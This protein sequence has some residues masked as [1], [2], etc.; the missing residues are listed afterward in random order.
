MPEP[1]RYF[2]ASLT[3]ASVI[4]FAHARKMVDH[5]RLA[6]RQMAL[7]SLALVCSLAGCS[8]SVDPQIPEALS[9][10]YVRDQM[11]YEVTAEAD[12]L[13]LSV[14]VSG[15]NVGLDQITREQEGDCFSW[16]QVYT[17]DWERLWDA[18]RAHVCLFSVAYV[19]LA[20]GEVLASPEWSRQLLLQDILGDSIPDGEYHIA[21]RL[22]FPPL[23]EAEPF[24]EITTGGAKLVGLR[25]N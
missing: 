2:A 5:S 1:T 21:V 22:Y 15:R 12:D 19:D 14:Q 3:L 20:P 6:T 18:E 9:D 4:R 17:Q 10:H 11:R 24:P 25:R 13:W 7:S 8:S 16:I 23:S